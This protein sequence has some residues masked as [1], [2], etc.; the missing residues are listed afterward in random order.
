VL[1]IVLPRIDAPPPLERP[2]SCFGLFAQVE[3][4]P[5]VLNA[6]QLAPLQCS[7]EHLPGYDVRKKHKIP[8]AGS[9]EDIAIGGA[10]DAVGAS[11][12]RHGLRC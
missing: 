2:S 10:D 9:T 11:L 12:R 7:D 8:Q 1:A 5:T 3:S 6:Q 4:A